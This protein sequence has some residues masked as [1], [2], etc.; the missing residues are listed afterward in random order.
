MVALG[1][2]TT[3]TLASVALAQAGRGHVPIRVDTCVPIE[4]AKFRRLLAIELST[5]PDDSL[6][7]AGSPSIALSCVDIWVLIVVEDTRHSSMSRRVDLQRVDPSARTRLMVLAVAELLLA[8]RVERRSEPSRVV[9]PPPVTVSGVDASSTPA[10][11]KPEPVVASTTLD[12]GE[13]AP[14]KMQPVVAPPQPTVTRGDGARVDM[15][16]VVV[17]PQPTVTRGE[18]ERARVNMQPVVAPAPLGAESRDLAPANVDPVVVSE[19]TRVDDNPADTREPDDTAPSALQLGAAFEV[20]AFTSAFQPI[21]CLTLR[22][23]VP[24][25]S[26]FAVRVGAQLG[27]GGLNGFLDPESRTRPVTVRLTTA[28]L[29]LALQYTRHFGDLAWAIGAGARVGLADFS[30]AQPRGSTVPATLTATSASAP[31]AG[32]LLTTSFGYRVSS[33][34]QIGV[35]LEL[36]YVTLQAHAVAPRSVVVTALQDAWGVASLGVDGSFE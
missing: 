32:P 21:P 2:L 27:Y 26:W 18:R 24:L 29:L 34:V 17:P 33:R 11:A 13:G 30:G 14:R 16:P 20:L 28:S 7:K 15:Q 5:A 6:Y 36:G 23:T 25:V 8:N 3:G 12:R 22:V 19:V 1:A 10:P 9:V 4:V 35:L 31:W